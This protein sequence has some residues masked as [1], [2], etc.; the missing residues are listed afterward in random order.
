MQ[1]P[2]VL[3]VGEPHRGQRA[4]FERGVR[5]IDASFDEWG[6]ICACLIV[7]YCLRGR[8][9]VVIPCGG[10][11]FSSPINTARTDAFSNAG[12]AFYAAFRAEGSHL[13]R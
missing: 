5:I 2:N 3:V 1:P 13:L 11:R 9:L 4:F 10:V 6:C 8:I 12:V 7:N